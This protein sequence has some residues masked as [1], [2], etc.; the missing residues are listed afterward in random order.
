[1]LTTDE[2]GEIP[3][4]KAIS[5]QVLSLNILLGKSLSLAFQHTNDA[6]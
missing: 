4:N 6:Y 2:E 1:M 5:R 3:F